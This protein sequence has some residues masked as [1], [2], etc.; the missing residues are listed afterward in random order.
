MYQK[1]KYRS[2]EVGD[3]M[4]LKTSELNKLNRAFDKIKEQIAEAC[5]ETINDICEDIHEYAHGREPVQTGNLQ[6][7]LDV[8]MPSY[9]VN[10]GINEFYGEVH[11]GEL[12]HIGGWY[13]TEA[14][15]Y[16]WYPGE[17]KKNWEGKILYEGWDKHKD[18]FVPELTKNIQSKLR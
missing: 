18:R 8:N 4:A 14:R 10:R 1:L 9:S 7:S 12:G 15:E 2:I 3:V 13:D 16:M 6:E 5:V 11:F 17:N